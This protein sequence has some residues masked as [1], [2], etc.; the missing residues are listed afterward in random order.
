M[1]AQEVPLQKIQIPNCE[2]PLGC[3]SCALAFKFGRVNA[4]SRTS[5]DLV[6]HKRDQVLTAN[7]VK[8]NVVSRSKRFPL[9]Q[10]FGS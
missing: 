10:L 4:I 5:P 6:F 1:F 9:C 3:F 8:Y 7:G 2:L